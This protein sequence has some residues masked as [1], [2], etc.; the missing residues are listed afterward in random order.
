MEKE[1]FSYF[2]DK[3]AYSEHRQLYYLFSNNAFFLNCFRKLKENILSAKP[4]LRV[5]T[6]FSTLF[7]DITK[8][9]PRTTLQH[10]PQT[11]VFIFQSKFTALAASLT[12]VSYANLCCINEKS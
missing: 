2:T 6:R 10:Y 11:L 9:K 3:Y 8:Q 7:K 4:I 5:L 1:K 12:P